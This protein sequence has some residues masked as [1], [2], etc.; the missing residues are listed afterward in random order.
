MMR[1]CFILF[2]ALIMIILLQLTASAAVSQYTLGDTIR[3]FSFSTYDGQEHS[4]QEVLKEKDAILL[5]IWA[6]WCGPCKREFPFMQEAYEEYKDS[7]EIIALSCEPTDT[8]DKLRNFAKENGLSFLIGQAP[9]QLLES[10]NV[11]SI[12]VTLVID[13]YGTICFME[14][15]AQPDTESFRRL[16][17]AFVGD[18]YQ[19][20]L[21]LD[22]V[23]SGKPDIAPSAPT[24]LAAALGNAASN[25]SNGYIWPMVT[26]EADGRQVVVS[27]NTGKVSSRAEILAEVQA[28][29]GDAILITFKT[30][31]EPL[32]D[33]MSISVNGKTIK[34]FGGEH[35]WMT[36]AI[37]VDAAGKQTVKISYTKDQI[38]DAGADRVWIDSIVVAND[39]KSAIADNP[40]YPVSEFTAVIPTADQARAVS[41]SD[42]NGLLAANFGDVRC[43]VVNADTVELNV[44]LAEDVDPECTL[45]YSSYDRSQIPVLQLLTT[46]DYA[47]STKVDSLQTT[48]AYCTFAAVYPDVRKN[49]AVTTLLFRDEE[50]LE[51]FV[52]RNGLGNW[53]YAEDADPETP[54][55]TAGSHTY[56]VRC[57]DQY[58]MPVAGVLLQ[59][60]SDEVCQVFM[61]DE[62]GEVAFEAE[63]YPWEIHVLQVPENY[64]AD[65][66]QSVFLPVEGGS[67]VIELNEE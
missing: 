67:A 3:E 7:V 1:K 8:P 29:V 66:L 61:T 55:M 12:P 11:T 6:S 17:D 63:A 34:H 40:S 54:V 32:Y 9:Q 58:G 24:E 51:S 19:E 21:L 33:L 42:P 37:P 62:D 53:H 35:D 25:P 56:T 10:I 26:A 14:A 46:R 5:N 20:S 65:L 45:V 39:A 15:G 18:G 41:I 31:T 30:S 47:S 2:L 27:T 13:R 4:F 38:T 57:I 48:G 52:V 49:H 60:C 36:Y 44:C 64:R 23:P 28:Q 59:V 22:A 50:N 16:F 43:Y